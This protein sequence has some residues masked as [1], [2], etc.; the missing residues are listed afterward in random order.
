MP[1]APLLLTLRIAAWRVRHALRAVALALLV[2][3]GVQVAVPA[4]PSTSAVV[5]TARSVRAGSPLTQADLRT[6]DLAPAPEGAARTVDELLGRTLVVDAPSGLPVVDDLLAGA[7]FDLDPPP[8]TVLLPLPLGDAGLGAVLRPGDRVDVVTTV[9]DEAGPRT[10]V[11]AERALVV[12]VR[13]SEDA[14]LAGTFA[15]STGTSAPQITVAVEPE[16]GRRLA[17]GAGQAPLGAVLVP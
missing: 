12:D 17:A 4:P 16:A 7:R 13:E 10:E 14:A 1:T 2:L 15:T 5:V 8:G 3:I 9:T 11:L 6:V